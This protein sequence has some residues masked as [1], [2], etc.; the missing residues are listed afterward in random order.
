MDKKNINR[1]L[2]IVAAVIAVI[3]FKY[4][5]LGQYLTL[6]YLKRITIPFPGNV[7]Q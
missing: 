2:L 6:E 5:G 4:L 7:S 3:L 1:I